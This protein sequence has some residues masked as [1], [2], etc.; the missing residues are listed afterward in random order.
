LKVVGFDVE[1]LESLGRTPMTSIT[2]PAEWLTDL[3]RFHG[4]WEGGM[5]GANICVIANHIEGTGGGPK[6][7][8][9]PYPETFV[10]RK[11]R[12]LF[13][14][15]DRKIEAQAGEILVV[16]A[17]T[18]HKFENFGPGPLETLD[19]HESGSFITEWLE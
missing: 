10:I 1:R 15:G 6:L 3:E 2:E 8:R 7:H 17:G 14:V 16:P 13:T 18:P 12:G 19:V 11:G 4:E 5:R 9:H